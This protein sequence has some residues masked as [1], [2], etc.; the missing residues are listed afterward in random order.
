[1]YLT[2]SS[3]DGELTLWLPPVITTTPRSL[4]RT[5]EEDDSAG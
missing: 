2:S 4:D 1:M 3:F 5:L